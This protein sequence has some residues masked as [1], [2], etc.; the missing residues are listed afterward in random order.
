MRRIF[1]GFSQ[2][3]MSKISEVMLGKELLSQAAFSHPNYLGGDNIDQLSWK[4][5]NCFANLEKNPNMF[6]E[7]SRGPSRNSRN[8][9]NPN[10][11]S[12]KLRMSH[13]LVHH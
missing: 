8:S 5:N 9:R 3:L 4:L 6:L 13:I 7:N 11:L 10:L 2:C 12:V 1:R